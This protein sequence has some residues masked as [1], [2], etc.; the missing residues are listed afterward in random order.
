MT[1]VRKQAMD[2]YLKSEKKGTRSRKQSEEDDSY[3]SR[4]SIGP[5]QQ[6]VVDA[7]V[8][9]TGAPY[10]HND[11]SRQTSSEQSPVSSGRT[12]TPDIQV[13]RIPRTLDTVLSAAPIVQPMRTGM[14]LPYMQT[15][16]RPFQSIGKPLD[17]FRTMFQ[18]QHPSISVEEL[19][20]HCSRAFGTRA[21]GQH[22]IPTLVKSPHAFLST[23]CIA[24]AHYDAIHNREVESLHTVALR[25]EVMHLI[26]QNIL[27][28]N[29]KVDDYNIIALT[30]LIASEIIGREETML[31]YHE[32]GI[33]GMVNMRGGLRQLGV[34][35]RVATTLSWVSLLSANLRE[36]T[37]NPMYTEFCAANSRRAY[38]NT[39]TIP[40]SPLFTPREEWPTIERSQRCSRRTLELL[41]DVRM[42]NDFFLHETR[43]SRQNSQSLKN[44][45]KKIT[46]YPSATVLQQS[47]NILTPNDWIHEAVRV[48]AVIQATAIIKRTPLSEALVHVAETEDTETSSTHSSIKRSDS[49]DSL[50]FLIS[51]STR[52]DSPFTSF[53]TSPTYTTALP[54]YDPYAYPFTT[55]SSRP[56]I[57]SISTSTS[58]TDL[59]FV[60]QLPTTHTNIDPVKSL[61]TRL[62]LALENSDLS[63]AWSDLA[64]VLLWVSLVVGAASRN[65]KD[66]TGKKWFAALAMRCAILLCFEHPQAVCATMGRMAEVVAGLRE[67]VREGGREG[68]RKRRRIG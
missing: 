54:T 34:N 11:R 39:A 16:P 14:C 20:F 66:R 63:S 47:N 5:D 59:F 37:P 26:H 58:S 32:K 65:Q 12:L 9:N 46:Q 67:V 41:K 29:T 53:S 60:P 44:L 36:I 35:G 56:S 15:T 42:M 23:L 52:H 2:S 31:D 24:S 19:K 13:S 10:F 30:Q 21:M 43:D 1:K 45:Y 62:Q 7:G 18:A 28:P 51:T 38:P 33:E 25:Q 3:T 4:T 64:G 40:E 55:T 57:S 49:D 6:D 22:W 50:N 27:N 8:S 48:A 17:P 61:L 68:G